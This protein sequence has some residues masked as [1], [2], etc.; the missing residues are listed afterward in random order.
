MMGETRKLKCRLIPGGWIGD[1]K[2][3]QETIICYDI[4]RKVEHHFN[5]KCIGEYEEHNEKELKRLT[6]LINQLLTENRML[7]DNEN[8]R[9]GMRMLFK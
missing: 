5:L 8:I 7:K 2:P 1:D 3:Q 4:H 9:N 6:D